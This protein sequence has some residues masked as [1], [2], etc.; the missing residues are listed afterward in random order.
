MN[1]Q[2]VKIRTQEEKAAAIEAL[3]E[4]TARIFREL[5]ATAAR[6]E[7]VEKDSMH[8]MRLMGRIDGLKQAMTFITEYEATH[9]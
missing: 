2:S 1:E 7:N 9:R 4:L 6:A 8:H 3:N 5:K